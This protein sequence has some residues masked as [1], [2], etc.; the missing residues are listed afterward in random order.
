MGINSA[1]P[2]GLYFMD[3]SSA[4]AE[5]ITLMAAAGA[6][7]HL[8]PT[9]QGNIVGHPVEPVIKLTGNPHTSQTMTEHIDLDVSGLL[10]RQL[11]LSNAAT[12]LLDLVTRT[13]NGRLTCA[14][15]LA[16]HEFA[17]TRLYQSA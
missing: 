2:A 13:T 17:L 4:A 3:S 10:N 7:V 15:T 1:R 14:E 12:M 6:V 16:H 5:F 8:F 9:G 11:T